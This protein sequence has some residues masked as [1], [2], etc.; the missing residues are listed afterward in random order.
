MPA[1]SH[2]EAQGRTAQAYCSKVL[3]Q[4]QSLLMED[5]CV[6]AVSTA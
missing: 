1:P 2:V 3:R 5:M 6:D 4:V